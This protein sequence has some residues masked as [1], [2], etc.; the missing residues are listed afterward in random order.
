ML[1]AQYPTMLSFS[2]VPS[3]YYLKFLNK[4]LN[5][6]ILQAQPGVIQECKSK[7]KSEYL[8]GVVQNPKLQ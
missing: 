5:K 7:S 1:S 8:L 6:L 3:Q 4:I 2:V